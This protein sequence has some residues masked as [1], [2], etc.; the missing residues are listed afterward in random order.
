MSDARLRVVMA[1]LAAIGVGVAIYLTVV[2]YQGSPPVCVGGGGACERVQ[3]SRYA[4]V[5]GIPVATIGLAGYVSI[6][7]ALLIR[8]DTGRLVVAGLALVG[9]GY[10]CYLTYLEL[11]VIDA[12]C[13]W[14]VT[15]AVLMAI[16]AVLAVTRVL[17]AP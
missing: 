6:L 2:H 11:W 17:R 14:C 12:V 5:M 13:Q 3:S 16:L 9:A 8:G 7:G 4:E 1:V 15:S 10:S